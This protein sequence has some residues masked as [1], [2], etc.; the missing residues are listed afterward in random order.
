[1]HFGDA[2]G[3]AARLELPPGLVSISLYHCYGL[4]PLGALPSSLRTLEL[5]Y[6]YV[7]ALGDLPAGLEHL[8]V[9]RA[10]PHKLRI[11]R[12]ATVD[13]WG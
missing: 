7:H 11:P 3:S 6:D 10:F 13:W 12:N 4:P 1:V 8:E 2:D 5:P 9:P